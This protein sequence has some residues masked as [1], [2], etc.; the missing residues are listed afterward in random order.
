MPTKDL[1]DLTNRSVIKFLWYPSRKPKMK[2]VLIK[3]PK[4]M[5]GIGAPDIDL[6]ILSFR[7]I[8][9]VKLHTYSSMKFFD[10]F[11]DRYTSIKIVR[12][13]EDN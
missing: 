7:I 10:Y 3:N 2:G 12:K 9:L 4:R 1:I 8:F 5:G 6:K 11:I 13:N